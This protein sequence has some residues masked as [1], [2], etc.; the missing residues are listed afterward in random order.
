[1]R[2]LT[3]RIDKYDYKLDLENQE[4]IVKVLNGREVKVKLI[5]PKERYIKYM[6]WDNYEL[7]MKYDGSRFWIC[8]EFRRKVEQYNARSVLAIDVNFDNVTILIKNSRRVIKA[9]KFS[10]PLRKALCHR[11]WIERIQKRYPKQWKYIK[12]IREAI[13][14]HG[15]KIRNIVYDSCHKIAE[16]MTNIALKYR[17]LIVVENLKNLRV[18][19]KRNTRFN[20]KLS[21]WAYRK[22][23]FYI[24]YGCLEK[25]I[26]SLSKM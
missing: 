18:N 21:L 9:K 14:K 17:S 3:A 2:K 4:L 24:E 25:G 23:L 16:E 11:I 10:F 13:R 22:L 5:A 20:K 1:M 15:R 6:N 19:G 26:P 8:I 7:I 12:G